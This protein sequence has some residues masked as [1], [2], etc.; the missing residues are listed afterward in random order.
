MFDCNNHDI[1]SA[2]NYM[3]NKCNVKFQQ[4]FNEKNWK[5]WKEVPEKRMEVIKMDS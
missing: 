2:N 1:V 4:C 3:S 5:E